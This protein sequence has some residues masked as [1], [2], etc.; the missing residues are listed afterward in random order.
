MFSTPR[1]TY[2][3]CYRVSKKPNGEYD[4]VYVSDTPAPYPYEYVKIPG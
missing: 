1:L 2:M 4:L 3:K